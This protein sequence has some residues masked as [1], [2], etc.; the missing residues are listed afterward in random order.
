MATLL[1]DIAERYWETMLRGDADGLLRAFDG[2]PRVDAP[3]PGTV[4]GADAIRRFVDGT[5]EWLAG[6]R[7][8]VSPVR[9]TRG[10]CRTVAE[11]ELHL[12][13]GGRDVHLP[14]AVVAQ[15]ADVAGITRLSVYHSRWPLTGTHEVRSPVLEADPDLDLPDVVGRYL[16][17]LAQGNLRA[18]M[19]CFAPDAYVREPAG[20][21]F[22]HRGE[23]ALRDLYLAFFENAGG[24]RLDEC[25]VTD[26]G[27]AVA[28]EYNVMRWGRTTLPPQAGIA[29]YER[30]PDDLVLTAARIYDDVT[31]PMEEALL[32]PH[33]AAGAQRME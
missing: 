1:P 4:R 3:H 25:T 23:E 29:V 27:V 26:D 13:V 14:T 31:P 5:R 16:V 15:R 12:R 24:I 33:A 18:V 2:E 9:T 28:V 11:Q 17:A 32:P 20:E 10:E 21:P 30:D 8:H 6:M 22:T 19:D 7:A